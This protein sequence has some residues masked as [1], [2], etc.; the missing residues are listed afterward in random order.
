MDDLDTQRWERLLQWLRDKHGMDTDALLVEPRQVPG[1]GRG[2][3]AARDIPPSATIFEV[4]S[5]ALMNVKTLL[6]LY[7]HIREGRLSSHQLVSLHLLLHRPPGEDDSLDSHFGPYIS[8]LP[9]DFSSHPLTW[10]IDHRHGK[11]DLWTGYLLKNLPPMTRMALEK[12]YDG[13]QK[14]WKAVVGIL[15]ESPAMLSLSSRRTLKTTE[16]LDLGELLSDYVWAWLNVNTRC[17]YYRLRQNR[18][19]PDNFTLCPILDFANHGPELTHIFPVVESDIWDVTIPRA[20]GSVKRA[21]TEPFVFFGPSDFSVPEGQELLLKYGA[22]SN[23]FL[24][25]EYGFVN[26]FD[27]GAVLSGRFPGEVDVQ[28]LVEDLIDQ[29]GPLKSQIR[30]TLHRAGYWGEWTLHSA[31]E[32]AHPSWRLITVLRLVCALQRLQ[33][34]GAE[35]EAAISAWEGVINGFVSQMSQSNEDAWRGTLLKMCETIRGRARQ[36]VSSLRSS[37]PSG[38]PP[39]ASWMVGNL[40]ALW[41][42]E[43]EVAEAVIASVLEGK[44]F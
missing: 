44:E 15:T 14:D 3:F 10:L 36:G 19:D 34:N 17:I 12:S 31:P 1:A 5:S 24:F 7:P 13:F 9:R 40:C 8:T 18:S 39:W 28:E 4:P 32:P 41:R 42:E 22:H 43:A 27:E 25:I 6:P 20:P 11:D 23:R 35:A 30:S 16:D 37:P 33:G 21:K 38:D 29:A 2:L 26:S